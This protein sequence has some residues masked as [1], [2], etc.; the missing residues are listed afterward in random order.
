MSKIKQLLRLH[1]TGKVSNRSIADEPGL[2]KE[3]VNTF[4]RKVKANNFDIDELLELDDPVLEGKFMAGSAACTDKRFDALKE[5]LPYYEKELKRKHVT[6]NLLWKE[7][8]STHPDGYRY[9]QFCFHLNQLLVA[10]KPVARLE[11]HPGEK[12]YLDFSGDTIDYIDRE[13]D[14]IRKAQVFVATFPYSDYTFAMACASQTTDDFLHALSCCLASFGGSPK[15]IVPDN[16][17]AAVIKTDKYEP[18]INRVMEDFANHYGF[19]VLPARVKKSRDKSSVENAVKIIYNRVYARLR[20]RTF[21]SIAEINT[22]FRDKVREHNQTRMQLRDYS[23]EE[24]FLAEEKPAL[25]P[26]P[27]TA[28]EKKYY[29]DLRVA[30]NGYICLGRDRHYYSVPYACIGKKVFVIY[31]RTLVQVYC[32]G[33]SVATHPRSIGYGYTTVKD[34]LCSAHRHY[35]DRSPEYYLDE[36]G[37]RS[38]VL[39]ELV[40]Q[41]FEKAL[42]PETVYRSCDGLLSL[43][44]KTELPLFERA[45]QMALDH[46]QRSYKFVQKVIE[47][48]TYLLDETEE[49]NRQNPLPEHE[50]I[51]GKEYYY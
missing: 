4:V 40:R 11:H 7:Y 22:A 33:K 47:N 51:R 30:V 41:I 20:N 19:V 14:S 6:R 17:K 27:C 48:K 43:H 12:L 34:H 42:I 8:I 23:R 16:L 32:E 46:G 35:M 1:R 29:A 45:C 38:C 2:D 18:D 10:R 44:R 24:K 50:N 9:T 25:T 36:A 31:T 13:A 5:Q 37:K 28:F 3:T 15:I 39:K 26:L 49:E 21:F